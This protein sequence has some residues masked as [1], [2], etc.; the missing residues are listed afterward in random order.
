MLVATQLE[1]WDWRWRVPFDHEIDRLIG[2]AEQELR[3]GGYPA[4]GQVLADLRRHAH[5]FASLGG[6]LAALEEEEMPVRR[7]ALIA[8]ASDVELNGIPSFLEAPLERRIE[9]VATDAQEAQD[10]LA[11]LRMAT[12]RSWREP[13]TDAL[14]I[15]FG[16][17]LSEV[18]RVG[19]R[20]RAESAPP[21][22]LGPSILREDVE[23]VVQRFRGEHPSLQA[24]VSHFSVGVNGGAGFGAYWPRELTGES[25]DRLEMSANP[26]SLRSVSLLQ[27]LAHEIAGHGVFYQALRRSTP[28]FVDQ[29]A[30]ALI[31][32]WATFAEWRLPGLAGPDAARL[33]WLDLLGANAD[34]VRLLVPRL[35][36]AEGYS[37]TQIESA[38]LAWTQ[39]PAYQMSYL[40]GGLW[41]VDQAGN[42]ED[43]LTVLQRVVEQPVGDFLGIY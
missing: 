8:A 15:V 33:A 38:L 16:Q 31:E 27:T 32:G 12:S 42:F 18:I 39:L 36:R 40:M 43:G 11:L 2:R 19:R 22:A 14:E 7:H 5:S 24:L 41:F 25:A 6:L 1:Q 4:Q 9:G 21:I 37:S 3:V 35:V 17:R 20:L 13:H 23:G 26:D 29:G 34:Q 10:L 28:V 30:L